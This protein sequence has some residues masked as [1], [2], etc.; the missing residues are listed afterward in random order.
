M[1]EELMVVPFGVDASA[2][3]APCFLPVNIL[4]FKEA[5]MLVEGS[6]QGIEIA[7]HVIIPRFYGVAA[8]HAHTY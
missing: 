2:I 6:P 8:T 3:S 7:V 5:V 1:V 4:A